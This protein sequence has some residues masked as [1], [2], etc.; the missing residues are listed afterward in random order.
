MRIRSVEG[1][2]AEIESLGPAEIEPRA[3]EA[4][5]PLA[6]IEVALALPRGGRAE[7]VVDGLT[8]LG[9]TAISAISSEHVRPESRSLPASRAERLRRAA[10]EACKQCGRLWPPRLDPVLPLAAWLAR[11]PSGDTLVLSPPAESALSSWLET[12]GRAG[13]T[14]WS[15]ASPLRLL[16]GPEG[17]FSESEQDLLR[18]S[19]AVAVRV[20]PHTL[21]IET[22]ALAAMSI[23]AEH[24]IKSYRS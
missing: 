7:D 19:G 6:W 18:A 11:D 20:G 8:Q 10:L 23:A 4:G 13:D 12:H 5:A 3:G 9:A 16:V 14:R 15:E 24:C 22:A 2:R 1:L 17:G 21:R